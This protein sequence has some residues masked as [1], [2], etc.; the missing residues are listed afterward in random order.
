MM[1]LRDIF[2]L[3]MILINAGFHFKKDSNYKRWKHRRA[4]FNPGFHRSVLITFIDQFNVKADMLTE[5]LSSMADGKT[6]VTLLNE[7]NN[8]TLDAIA[9]V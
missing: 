4:L 5:R 3:Q 2:L 6:V 1:I 8:T 7:L 9:Q